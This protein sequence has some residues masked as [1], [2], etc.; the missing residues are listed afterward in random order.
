MADP[1]AAF[2]ES[3]SRI[4]HVAFSTLLAF[5]ERVSGF[6]SLIAAGFELGG[7]G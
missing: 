2:Y 1:A 4:E 5:G 7:S 6:D 3:A